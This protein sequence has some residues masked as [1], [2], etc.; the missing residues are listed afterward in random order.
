MNY[1]GLWWNRP[2]AREGGL[3]FIYQSL[4]PG[5]C[6]YTGCIIYIQVCKILDSL[7]PNITIAV[8]VTWYL[9]NVINSSHFSSIR[10][11]R[12]VTCSLFLKF[13]GPGPLR[14]SSVTHQSST[15]EPAT[16]SSAISY[17]GYGLACMSHVM[18]RA[19][20]RHPW[21]GL[22]DFSAI[23]SDISGCSS[24]CIWSLAELQPDL[25]LLEIW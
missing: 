15:F 13:R 19:D 22:D 16:R 11:L 9:K 12:F 3:V 5:M 21:V 7:Q 10:C 20:R 17:D 23:R 14:Q 18:H 2:K 1:F 25:H 4:G 8:K 24:S 6:F